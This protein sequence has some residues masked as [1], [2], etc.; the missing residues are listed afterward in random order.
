MVGLGLVI[1]G[2]R[3]LSS[4]LPYGPYIALAAALWVFAGRD[5]LA[6]YAHLLGGR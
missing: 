5:L 4:R 6:W 1:A 2:K 3:A